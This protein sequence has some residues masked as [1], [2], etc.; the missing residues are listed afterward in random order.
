MHN[1]VEFSLRFLVVGLKLR[2]LILLL[3]LMVCITQIIFLLDQ[4]WLYRHKKSFW[5]RLE[6]CGR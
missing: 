2:N 3:L 6:C 1:Q 5:W 4:N